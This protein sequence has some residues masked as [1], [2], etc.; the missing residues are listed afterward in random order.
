MTH[1]P[2]PPQQPGLFQRVPPAIFPPVLGLLGLVTAWFRAVGVFD[3]PAAPVQM[4][5]GAV[6]ILFAFC[7]AAYAA[8]VVRNPRVLPQDL[9]NLPGR[10]GLA[11]W[12]VAVMVEAVLML[13]LS[14]AL[15]K[16]LLIVGTLCLFCIAA[17]VL[18]LRLRGVDTAGPITPAMHLVF[19]GFI[20]IPLAAVPMK[21]ATAAMPWL[22]WYCIVASIFIMAKSL[23]SLVLKVGEPPLRPLQAIHLAPASFVATGALLTGQPVLSVLALLWASALAALL[24]WRVRWLTEGPFSGFWSAFTFPVT[25]YAGALLTGYHVFEVGILKY[26]GGLVLIAATLFIPVIAYRILKLWASGSLA[27]KTNA[28]MA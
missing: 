28:A 27:V 11:A 18:P 19:V 8:K 16:V 21:M 9:G 2:P 17:Y 26:A 7:T 3:L 10:T 20:L 15:A 5:S 13:G 6:S 4:A 12:C 22:I 25:A 23:R 24:L 14:I 1:F